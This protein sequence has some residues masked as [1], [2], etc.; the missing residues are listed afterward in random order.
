MEKKPGQE[1][2]NK[3]WRR[4]YANQKLHAEQAGISNSRLNKFFRGK[5]KLF[6]WELWLLA[7]SFGVSVDFLLDD[8]QHDPLA[9]GPVEIPSR[10]KK[11]KPGRPQKVTGERARQYETIEVKSNVGRHPVDKK[12]APKRRR[13]PS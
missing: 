13:S 9:D 12:P 5:G 2:I 3:I 4:V 11:R 8:A 6:P 10:E 1:A 7:K